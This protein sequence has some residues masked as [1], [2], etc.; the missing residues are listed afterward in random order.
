MAT[1]GE[2]RGSGFSG[3]GEVLADAD[4][5]RLVIRHVRLGDFP[6]EFQRAV[7]RSPDIGIVDMLRQHGQLR[8]AFAVLVPCRR[9]GVPIFV[10]LGFVVAGFEDA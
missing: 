5:R 3:K 2:G 8:V 9:D 4:V 7:R 1:G 6:A 10:D